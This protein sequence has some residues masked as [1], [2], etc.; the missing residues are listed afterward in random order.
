MEPVVT[1]PK[2]LA[3]TLYTILN[4]FYG[5]CVMQAPQEAARLKELLDA[6]ATEIAKEEPARETKNA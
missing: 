3:T 5:I 2:S 4:A 6:F 1:I